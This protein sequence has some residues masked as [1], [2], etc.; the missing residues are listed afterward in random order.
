MW[1]LFGTGSDTKPAVMAVGAEVDV[2]VV[3]E[4]P[5]WFTQGFSWR[6]G[7]L[8]MPLV[9]NNSIIVHLSARQAL[10]NKSDGNKNF[11]PVVIIWSATTSGWNKSQLF[12]TTEATPSMTGTDDQAVVRVRVEVCTSS[13]LLIIRPLTL[14]LLSRLNNKVVYK[15]NLLTLN[16]QTE[17]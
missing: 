3:N 4:A 5:R 13:Q 9:T 17:M 12:I 16:L 1:F 10:W 2:H 15:C 7:M 8:N 6:I 14:P 11:Y